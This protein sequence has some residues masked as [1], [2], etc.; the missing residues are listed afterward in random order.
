M[1]RSGPGPADR[2]ETTLAELALTQIYGNVYA[3]F[4]YISKKLANGLIKYV[5]LIILLC[6]AQ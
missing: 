5:L 4:V 2:E 6:Y 3:A 1:W